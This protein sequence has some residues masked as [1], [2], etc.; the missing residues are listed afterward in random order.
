MHATGIILLL[1]VVAFFAATRTQVGRDELSRQIERSFSKAYKGELRIGKLTGNL[2]NTLYAKNVTL[3]NPEGKTVATIDSMVVEPRWSDLMRR[4]F[5][6]RRISIF[7]PVI[8][9]TILEDGDLDLMLALEPESRDSVKSEPGWTFQSALISLHDGLVVTH[10]L[11]DPPQIVADGNIFDFTNSRFEHL[12]LEARL[13]W[14]STIPQVDIVRFSGGIAD[15]MLQFYGGQ[16]Q[17]LFDSNRI[18]IT[19]LEVGVGES[20]LLL[21]GFI[22]MPQPG[23]TVNWPNAPFLVDLEPSRI[24]FDEL[25]E[26]L[27]KLPLSGTASISAHIQGPLSDLTISWLRLGDRQT[28][29]ELSGTVA[30]LPD[31]AA[32]DLSIGS[33]NL[34]V[35]LLQTWIP[36]LQIRETLRMDSLGIVGYAGGILRLNEDIPN[37]QLTGDLSLTS[38]RGSLSSNFTID[39]PLSDSVSFDMQWTSDRLDLAS[40]TGIQSLGSSLSGTIQTFGQ[41]Y[42]PGHLTADVRAFYSDFRLGRAVIPRLTLTG[43]TDHGQFDVRIR[44]TQTS[45]FILLGANGNMSEEDSDY[46]I[47]L[48]GRNADI[49]PLLGVDSLETRLNI[50]AHLTGTGTSDD[51]LAADLEISFDSSTVILGKR[52]S[53]IEPHTVHLVV[54]DPT[55]DRPRLSLSGDIARI[56]VSG[57][58]RFPLLSALGSAW[59]HTM[60]LAVRR[61]KDKPLYSP[62]TNDTGLDDLRE[63][64]LWGTATAAL[65]TADSLE[66]VS[67]HVSGNLF[68]IHHVSNYW[69]TLPA[70]NISGRIEMDFSMNDQVANASVNLDADSLRI[71][72]F[73][74]TGSELRGNFNA[75]RSP[76]IE[77]SARAWL[78][79]R[80]DSIRVGP[81]GFRSPSLE[82]EYADRAATVTA[83]SAGTARIDSIK[84][85]V[86]LRLL[87]DRN[88]IT[89]ERLDIQGGDAE[90][91]IE[92]RPIIDLFSDGMIVQEALLKQHRSGIPTGQQIRAFGTLSGQPQD[93]VFVHADAVILHEMSNFLDLNPHFGGS[94]NA[95]LAVTGG[96]ERPTIAGT[97]NISQFSLDHRIL[98]DLVLTSRF[99]P[100]SPD[101]DIRLAIT[102]ADTTGPS[103]IFGT[104]NPAI[105]VQNRLDIAGTL[106]LPGT[107]LDGTSDTGT[108]DLDV[109][110]ERADI[111]FLEYIFGETDNAVGFIDGTGNITGTFL[112]PVFN[113]GLEIHEGHFN[114]PAFNLDLGL[115]GDLRIDAE[116]IRI[117][118][119]SLVD[120]TG[121]TA[122]ITGSLFFNDYRFFTLDLAG[123]LQDFQ[124]MNVGASEDLPFYGYLWASGSLTLDGPLYGATLRSAN[125]TTTADSELFIPV[126]ESTT[127]TDLSYIV[128]SDSTG[129]IPDFR[130]LASRPFLLAH[131]PDSE[132]RFIDALD[133]DLSIFAPPGSTVHLVIDPLLGDVI[134]AVSTGRIQLQ[135]TQGEFFT[136]GQL[137]VSGGDYL[138]TVGDV[139]VRRFIIDEG[140]SITWNGDSINATL[141]IPATYRTRASR[142]GLGG[143]S[144]DTRGLIPLI[145]S[146]Q[147]SGTVES[148]AVDLSLSIDRS[149]QN[150]LGD[151][152]AL[153]A[154]L[155]QP[156]RA[157][158]YAISVLVINSFQ[159]TTDN[160]SRDTGGQLAFNSVSQL[161]SSQVNRFVNEALPNVDFSFGLQGENAQDLDITYGVAL[162]LLD[163]RLIIRGE[164]IY[165]GSRSDVS[166]TREGLQG[167]FVVEVRLSSAVS[168]EVFFRREGDILESTDLLNTAGAGLSYQ[169]EFPTWKSLWNKLF[170]WITPN[171]DEASS[172]P[173]STS[174]IRGR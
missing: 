95:Q 138:F 37:I 28:R 133:M 63:S 20:S 102:P 97:L 150:I 155:N 107:R 157:T 81:Q 54:R 126:E 4:Q 134:N 5:S 24:S 17:F 70:L 91:I 141:D 144:S 61:E 45:G 80:S 77:R 136:F 33:Q 88:Q 1:I 56:D 47:E 132:R 121:G 29:L 13:D 22:E 106:R 43:R 143:S 3:L 2:L 23:N 93:T 75:S 83:L 116:A 94:L 66:S 124:I 112:E 19:G 34:S 154:Q 58:I 53:R 74:M 40:W 10:N 25:Q 99:I 36:K 82:L 42:R 12:E 164:G 67:V 129:Y 148:P 8:D 142:A 89:I 105:H 92:G 57:D 11:G 127:S 85:V 167:E 151:Y 104:Q 78:R 115:T 156:D 68:G 50:D 140:G 79:I 16:S 65:A 110:V 31:S 44:A 130:Q 170:G 119:A 166:T 101:L 71:G 117:D 174:S 18:S 159:L 114:I 149:N 165:Q 137:A 98:G 131:R 158:E 108:L 145:V 46:T 123:E 135:R 69:P 161:V 162:R 173:D 84:V 6:V 7:R 172:Q 153:E 59:G 26:L 118:R 49:G 113:F 100:G 128:F 103:V 73:S 35:D 111:F 64:I 109:A 146:L 39:G 87:D 152:Q 52:S 51:R 160:V 21:S 72:S 90:W 125:A 163:E 60:L 171:A 96:S 48:T 139:F 55:S 9:L 41:G 168:L 147:I 14:E 122:E 169:T 27:P 62:E 32:F 30:G 15:G 120:I 86:D 76:S 38:D